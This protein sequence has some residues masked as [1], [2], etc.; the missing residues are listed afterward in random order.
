MRICMFKCLKIYSDGG[1]RGNPGPAAGA[2]VILTEADEIL[3]NHSIYLGK[4]TNNQAEYEALIAALEA[5]TLLNVDEIICYLD[6]ELVCRQLTGQYRVRNEDLQKLW[7]RARDL[8]SHFKKVSFVNVPR[9]NIWIK[10][11]D[12][13]VNQRLDLV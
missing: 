11:A 8:L 6:S 4:R 9:T 1:A 13:L 10:K 2:Y 7:K 12:Q 5:A 3:K